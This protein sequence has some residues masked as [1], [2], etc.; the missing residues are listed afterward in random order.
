MTV[1]RLAFVLSPY[2][3]VSV[4]A[5][6]WLMILVHFLKWTNPGNGTIPSSAAAA[7][8]SVTL[9]EWMNVRFAGFTN[10]W[11]IASFVGYAIYFGVGGFLHVSCY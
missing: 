9:A 6:E 8:G 11:L 4:P 5:A 1:I 7:A 10:V 3:H 2:L